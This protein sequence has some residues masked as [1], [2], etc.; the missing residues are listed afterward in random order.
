MPDP[1]TFSLIL[2]AI[3]TF[4]HVFKDASPIAVAALLGIGVLAI[5]HKRGP[6]RQMQNNHLVHLQASLDKVVENTSAGNAKLAQIS[7]DIQFL[8]GRLQ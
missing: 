1:T 5:L 8:K 7:E 6:I 3:E 4:L 2:S